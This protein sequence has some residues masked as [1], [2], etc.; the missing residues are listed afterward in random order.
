MLRSVRS[1][2][3]ATLAAGVAH[4]LRDSPCRS[5]CEPLASSSTRTFTPA[6]ARSISA[7][8]RRRPSTPSFHRKVSKCTDAGAPH[9]CARSARRRRRRSRAPRPCCRATAV[10]SVR[11]GERWASAR[12]WRRRTRSC[13]A[14][15]RWRRIDQIT[16]ASTT[17]ISRTLATATLESMTLPPAS[18]G[19]AASRR[20]RRERVGAGELS[21]GGRFKR[22]SEP[23]C[24]P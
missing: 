14:G 4:L 15:S 7:S 5:S 12:R 16:S 11:P 2:K 19:Y 17:M 22:R 23:S 10:P 24:R 1:W 20:L 13:R 21:I 8:A 18:R 9:G 3:N 6:R